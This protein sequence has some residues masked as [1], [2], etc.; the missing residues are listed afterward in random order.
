[1]QSISLAQIIAQPVSL[2]GL[3]IFW[4]GI[5]VGL[6]GLVDWGMHHRGGRTLLYWAIGLLLLH[7]IQLPVIIARSGVHVFLADMN[8]FIA[9]AFPA[10]F[11]G[12]LLVYLGVLECAPVQPSRRL[13]VW[14]AVELT[15]AIGVYTVALF[16]ANVAHSNF[17]LLLV[18]NVLLYLP[19][20]VLVFS[21]VWR[22]W[23]AKWRQRRVVTIGLLLFGGWSV[24]GIVNHLLV[25]LK[26]FA[27]PQEFWFVAITNYQLLYALEMARVPLLILGLV[28]L[29]KH[30]LACSNIRSIPTQ[31]V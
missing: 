10:A 3:I 19:L 23:S 18:T 27:Y 25:M 6:L 30:A 4:V 22:W 1:M 8:T 15:V 16:T 14:V 13:S 9:F 2:I 5:G 24:F 17:V 11:A 29:R 7:W 12:L 20:H 28:L 21:L 26:L 31:H